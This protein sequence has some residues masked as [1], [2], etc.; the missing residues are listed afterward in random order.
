LDAD[1]RAILYEKFPE[2]THTVYGFFKWLVCAPFHSTYVHQCMHLGNHGW[3]GGQYKVRT[4]VS[5]RGRSRLIW[6]DSSEKRA[7]S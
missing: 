3:L 4:C 2:E 6:I 5:V 7:T 1:G